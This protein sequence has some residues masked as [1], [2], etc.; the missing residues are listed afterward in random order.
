M[1]PIRRFPRAVSHGRSI[2][3][4]GDHPGSP[5]AYNKEADHRSWIAMT[6]FFNE[7]LKK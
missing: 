6:D 4:V 1:V 7:Y 5:V 3:M 2:E